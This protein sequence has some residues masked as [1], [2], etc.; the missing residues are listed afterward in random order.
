MSG[1][2]NL[3]FPAPGRCHISVT[4][5]KS[6]MFVLEKA[7]LNHKQRKLLSNANSDVPAKFKRENPLPM[8]N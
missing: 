5:A 1:E 3:V 8:G 2:T 4:V 7:F 6:A